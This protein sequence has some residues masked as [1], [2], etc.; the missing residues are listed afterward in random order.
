M[1]AFGEQPGAAS[2]E[3]GDS[4]LLRYANGPFAAGAG[5]TRIRFPTVNA[6]QDGAAIAAAGARYQ[7]GNWRL[8]GLYSSVRNTFTGAAVHA[9]ELGAVGFYSPWVLGFSVERMQGNGGVD[10]AWAN[11][12]NLQASYFLSKRTYLYAM[13][14]LQRTNSGARATINTLAPSSDNQQ[15]VYR[16]GITTVF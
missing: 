10:H 2:R 8:N 12:L 13:S 5:Y 1:H 9:L 11:Q 15:G 4:L 6:G 14:V 7:I 16:L 3:T